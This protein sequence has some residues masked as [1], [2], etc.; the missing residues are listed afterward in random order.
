MSTVTLQLEEPFWKNP[1][2]QK[3]ISPESLPA[4]NWLRGSI[5]PSLFE[6]EQNEAIMCEWI[7]RCD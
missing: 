5:R 2:I 6:E 4:P 3:E 7:D 1:Q